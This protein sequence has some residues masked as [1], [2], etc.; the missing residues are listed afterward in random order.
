[1]STSWADMVEEEEDEANAS[2]PRPERSGSVARRRA[3]RDSEANEAAVGCARPLAASEPSSF[4]IPPKKSKKNNN[5]PQRKWR[6]KIIRRRPISG[7]SHCSQQQQRKN[8]V[9]SDDFKRENTG[10]VTSRTSRK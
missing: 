10:K 2:E 9:Q 4:Q 8:T 1:M 3:E 5:E 6:R 7:L